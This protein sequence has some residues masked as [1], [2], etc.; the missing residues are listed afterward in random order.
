MIGL[1]KYRSNRGSSKLKFYIKDIEEIKHEHN[2]EVE[3][4]VQSPNGKGSDRL[5]YQM[6]RS[7]V[8]FGMISVCAFLSLGSNSFLSLN[9]LPRQY[10][11]EGQVTMFHF[12]L[13]DFAHEVVFV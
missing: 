10:L 1:K 3:C 4:L 12:K 11:F 5:I 9:Y 6:N 2:T 13:K 7:K 8:M